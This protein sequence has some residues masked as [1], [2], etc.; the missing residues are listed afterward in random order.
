MRRISWSNRGEE[1]RGAPELPHLVPQ[2]GLAVLDRLVPRR[3]VKII[4]S[5]LQKR[6]GHPASF[7]NATKTQPRGN[8]REK[9][10]GG[11]A[12]PN[13]TTSSEADEA[14]P[15]PPAPPPSLS[16][17]EAARVA[18]RPR[19]PLNR[20]GA[21]TSV[22]APKRCRIS[23]ESFVQSQIVFHRIDPPTLFCNCVFKRRVNR[24][25]LGMR[26]IRVY[27]GSVEI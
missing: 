2:R 15:L 11:S 27:Q 23:P 12:S 1:G 26:E 8:S 20:C 6:Y 21:S 14:P 19:S 25:G 3:S 10:E 16:D 24:C 13:A 9:R 22:N 4:L 17:C 18:V 7:T 5:A